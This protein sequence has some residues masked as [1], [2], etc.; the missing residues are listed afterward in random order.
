MCVYTPDSSHFTLAALFCSPPPPPSA[1]DNI[2]NLFDAFDEVSGGT[3]NVL[4]PQALSSPGPVGPEYVP[5]RLTTPEY[6]NRW[7][8]TPAEVKAVVK[9]ISA[10]IQSLDGLVTVIAAAVGIHHIESIP[11]TCEV[12]DRLTDCGSRRAGCSISITHV[13]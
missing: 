6:G 7:G 1:T 4:I 12:S 8:H 10:G 3:S 13:A 9:P 2:V 5:A 11:K